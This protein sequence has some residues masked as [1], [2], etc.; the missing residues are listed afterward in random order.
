MKKALLIVAG[1]ML[2]SAPPH[3]LAQDPGAGVTEVRHPRELESS[4]TAHPVPESGTMAVGSL[5]LLAAA[6]F[7]KRRRSSSQS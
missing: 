1:L 4:E 6:A 5:G 7:M 2:L 3:H